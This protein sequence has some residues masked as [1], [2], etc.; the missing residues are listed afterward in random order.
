MKFNY[1]IFL[2]ILIITLTGCKQRYSPKPKGYLRFDLQHKTEKLFIF[3]NC[4]FSFSTA[5]YFNIITKNNCWIDLEYKKHNATIYITYKNIENNLFKLLEESRNMV[6]KHTIKADAIN[7]KIYLNETY[8]TYGT[9]YDIKGETA[10]SVQFHLTDS[11]NN[12]IRGA[13]YFQ[14]TPNQDSLQPIMQYLRDDI[15]NIMESLQWT[16][17]ILSTREKTE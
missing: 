17:D 3:E 6:Y 2:I 9:L 11:I 8:N 16:N 1:Y 14:V 5:D 12:F 10:S 13:L 15:I 4:P 7:E